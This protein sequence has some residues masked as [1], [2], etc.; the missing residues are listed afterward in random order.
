VFVPEGAGGR[1]KGG[2][3]RENELKVSSLGVLLRVEP[4]TEMVRYP[5][6][7]LTVD[8]RGKGEKTRSGIKRSHRKKRQ[9][10]GRLPEQDESQPYSKLVI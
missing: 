7:N 8:L 5:E 10:L 4:K 3:V 1:E 6:K 2:R 9:I